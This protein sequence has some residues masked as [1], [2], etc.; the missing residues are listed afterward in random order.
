ML[1]LYP[2]FEN[3]TTRITITGV[4]AF[5]D[6]W[7]WEKFALAKYW[8]NAFFGLFISLLQFFGLCI[9]GLF[10]S[11]HVHKP[12]QDFRSLW[13]HI[14]YFD[15]LSFDNFFREENFNFEGHLNQ[16]IL[17]FTLLQIASFDRWITQFHVLLLFCFC[18]E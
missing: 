7:A 16:I 2:Q 6:F 13:Y 15:L 12:L 18:N 8:P 14:W 4:L 1:I 10:T 11:V 5:C 17:S 3:S 9:F